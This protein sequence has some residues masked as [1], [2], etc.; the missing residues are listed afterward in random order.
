MTK[1]YVFWRTPEGRPSDRTGDKHA[2]MALLSRIGTSS[3]VNPDGTISWPFDTRYSWSEIVAQMAAIVIDPDGNELNETDTGLIIAAAIK[4]QIKATGGAKPILGE[5]LL[6][7]ADTIASSFF[8]E[9]VADYV[10]ITSM[11]VKELPAKK[12]H[13][14]GCVVR[15]IP[16]ASN[17]F[18]L[19]SQMG[20][21]HKELAS[22]RGSGGYTAVKVTT[23]GR[24]VSE[25]VDNALDALHLLRGLWT[26]I[27]TYGSVTFHLSP[28]KPSS[29]GV[30]HIG[31]IHT[32]HNIDGTL[33]VDTYWYEP[34]YVEDQPIYQP[35]YGWSKIEKGR[36]WAQRQLLCHRH[37]A[38]RRGD[39]VHPR[40]G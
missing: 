25:A 17:T 37:P 12:I 16:P 26:L 14:R 3:T 11:S 1:R 36:K 4:T 15:A 5:S 18:P 10:L 2:P 13:V 6:K 28:E 22:R 23:K 7:A 19:P 9:P 38:R 31:P 34:E 40:H 24:S 39:E 33:A 35:Q 27:G 8:R 21:R 32:L 29:I 20:R 30:I